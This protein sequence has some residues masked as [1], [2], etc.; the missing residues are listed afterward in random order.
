MG[1]VGVG[2]GEDSL[3]RFGEAVGK[4]AAKGWGDVGDSGV[5]VKVV[6]GIKDK[7]HGLHGRG[8]WLKG[9]HGGVDGGCGVRGDGFR[10]G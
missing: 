4:E 2:G 5:G 8:E 1:G 10:V 6:R 7:R 9:D 3:D